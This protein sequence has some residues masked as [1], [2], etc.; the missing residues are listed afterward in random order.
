MNGTT[1][2]A[3]RAMVL[4]PP[5]MTIP[6]SNAR[7]IPVTSLDTPKAPRVASA[8]ELACTALNTRPNARIRHTEKTEAA[9][10][11]FSPLAM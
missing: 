6:A 1:H 7:P 4:M 8:I 10:G 2:S 5:K 11:A 3:I 9:Q